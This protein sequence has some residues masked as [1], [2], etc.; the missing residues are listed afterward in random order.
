MVQIVYGA[1]L[2]LLSFSLSLSPSPPLSLSVSASRIRGLKRRCGTKAGTEIWKTILLL[3][4]KNYVVFHSGDE[5]R[6]IF[7]GQSSAVRV[8]ID[9]KMKEDD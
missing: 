7:I 9:L 3:T 6:T 4:R 2:S 5:R 8:T 1:V